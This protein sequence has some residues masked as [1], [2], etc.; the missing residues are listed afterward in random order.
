LL[1]VAVLAAGCAS[2]TV[3]TDYDRGANFARFSTYEIQ[4]GPLAIEDAVSKTPDE[5]VRN[6]LHGAL[7]DE[8][9]AKGIAP[10]GDRQPDMIVTYAVTARKRRE[11]VEI[12]SETDPNWNYGGDSIMP[13]DVKQAIVVIDVIDAST[14]KLVWRSFAEAE[15]KDVASEKF[16]QKAVDKALDKFPAGRA[17]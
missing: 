15:N 17:S 9:A 2:T 8:L 16:L 5:V 4:P 6:R 14:G 13:R 10:A 11:L 12:M 3:R 7:V 1:L